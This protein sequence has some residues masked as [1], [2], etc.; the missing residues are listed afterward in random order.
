MYT[1]VTSGWK[2]TKIW[3]KPRIVHNEYLYI[4]YFIEGF[5]VLIVF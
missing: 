5:K 1:Q 2:I 4:F 3:D